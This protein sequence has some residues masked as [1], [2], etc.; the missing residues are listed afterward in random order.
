MLFVGEKKSGKSQL[1]SRLLDQQ[2]KDELPS[3]LALEYQ[4]TVKLNGD[5][6]IK[7]NV[8]E[9][10]GGRNFSN[11]LE[12]VLTSGSIASTT[13][14]IVIDL[15]NPYNAI[16][17]AV[18][19]LEAIRKHSQAALETL[20]QTN[21]IEI[22]EMNQAMR[23][24]WANHVDRDKVNAVPIP[25]VIIGSKFDEYAKMFEPQLKKLL[26]MALRF[27][28]QNNGC[29]LVFGSVREKKPS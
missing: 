6:R 21:P 13:V 16:E 18:Y 5:K 19:W 4:S 22:A 14:C 15:S 29:D 27:I 28:A 10:G 11:L 20:N 2:T 8:Y 1:I 3:T 23:E 7:T 26:C 17:T 24:K 12:A 9:L 25:V